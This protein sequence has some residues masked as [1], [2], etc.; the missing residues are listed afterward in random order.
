[1]FK[2]FLVL[3]QKILFQQHFPGVPVGVQWKRIQLVTMRLQVRYLAMLSGL[4]IR[5]RLKLWCRSQTR[6][7]SHV[8][9]A[10]AVAGSC[11]CDSTPTW[12]L[13]YVMGS[14]L[15]S[16]QTSKQN[17]NQKPTKQKPHVPPVLCFYRMPTNNIFCIFSYINSIF[18]PWGLYVS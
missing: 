14:A 8:A 7:R 10:V 12:E 2:N 4:R 9:V 6:L 16:K 1:M 17:K 15:K 18:S 11:S 13:P 3:P 5:S